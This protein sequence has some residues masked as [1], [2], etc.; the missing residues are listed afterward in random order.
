[1]YITGY[2]TYYV[3]MQCFESVD[4]ENTAYVPIENDISV[5]VKYFRKSNTQTLKHQ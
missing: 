3:E 5:I 1:M 4:E 2:V